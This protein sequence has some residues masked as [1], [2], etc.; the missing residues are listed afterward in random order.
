MF[1][2]PCE[3]ISCENDGACT[4]TLVSPYYI[5]GC[6]AGFLGENCEIG[7]A[8]ANKED[9]KFYVNEI[10][11]TDFPRN[12][13]DFV[14]Q[15]CVKQSHIHVSITLLVLWNLMQMERLVLTVTARKQQTGNGRAQDVKC[16]QVI[17]VLISLVDLRVLETFDSNNV[18]L[19]LYS[20]N[21]T[22]GLLL[23]YIDILKSTAL[24]LNYFFSGPLWAEPMQ[25]WNMWRWQ[26]GHS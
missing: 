17:R 26:P 15:R 11:L 14:L 8:C 20:S 5:C 19:Q 25:Q 9:L 3:S 23:L 1:S 18:S 10:Y 7:Q 13:F 2:A 16:L 24:N 22:M 6:Q 4:N 21:E 12:L